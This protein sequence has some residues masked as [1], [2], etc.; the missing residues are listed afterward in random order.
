MNR[1]QTEHEVAHLVDAWAAA[2]LHGDVAFLE[3]ALADDFI[4]IGP[5]G[6]MLSKEEWI[7]RHQSGDLQ[8]TAFS[9]DEV[10]IRSYPDAALVTCRQAQQAT[11]RGSSIPGQFRASLMFAQQDGQ[12]R[13]VGLQLSALGQFQPP[14]PAQSSLAEQN[15]RLVRRALDEVFAAGD[16]TVLNEIFDPAFIN[17]EAGPQTPPGPE[18]LKVTVGWLHA[19]FSDMHYDIEDVITQGD[20]VVVRVISRGRHTGPFLGFP[21]TGKT[22][23][24]HQVHIY[25]IAEGKIIEHW[26]A[27]DDLGQGIQLG[28]IPGGPPAGASVGAPAARAPQP[29]DEEPIALPGAN[30]PVHFD[31]HVRSLF[32]ERDRQSMKFAF[33]LWSYDDVTT[34][35]AGILARVRAGSM[36]CDGAWPQERVEVFQR[37]VDAGMPR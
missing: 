29:T 32:R 14:V 1:E 19:S 33:D 25:R 30:E 15:T 13:L 3:S 9:V 6:F 16:F 24:A 20:K 12:W 17:H 10:R 34:H 4:G 21:P 26:A 23:A 2:E 18:G 8:Y 7:A 37:W 31:P 27:R 36:P 11:Y 5:L 28:M 35:A 22:F